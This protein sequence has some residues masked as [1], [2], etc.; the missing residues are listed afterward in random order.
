MEKYLTTYSMF[1]INE[2]RRK[3]MKILKKT[4]LVMLALLMFCVISA[5]A[6]VSEKYVDNFEQHEI[7]ADTN[8]STGYPGT[9]YTSEIFVGYSGTQ[10]TILFEG[11]KDG[12]KALKLSKYGSDLAIATKSVANPGSGWILELSYDLKASHPAENATD[13]TLIGATNIYGNNPLISICYDAEKGGIFKSSVDESNIAAYEADKW[14]RVIIRQTADGKRYGTILDGEGN[15]VIEEE[16]NQSWGQISAIYMNYAGKIDTVIDNAVL[17]LY[18]PSVNAPSVSASSVADGS[19]EVARN[20]EVVLD[21]DQSVSGNVQLINADG[22]SVEG[23][24]ATTEQILFNRLK[25]SFSGLLERKTEYKLVISGVTNGTFP[26]SEEIAFTTEDLHIWNDV[27]VTSAAPNGE[28]TNITFTIGEKYGYPVFSGAALAVLYENGEM[29]A[30]D[31][32]NLEGTATGEITKSF[33][34]GTVPQGARVC[35]ILI[36]TVIEPI[37]LASGVLTN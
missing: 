8:F 22:T 23:I 26:A 4:V 30:C 1:T 33:S 6:E 10:G 36:D 5:S 15:I 34:L 35:I 2:E 27:A 12:K 13:K 24:T 31:M 21:F 18:N 32:V 14:Y 25:V 28:K 7:T 17:T 11:G 9:A 19:K 16:K 37:P 3:K 20:A 29:K